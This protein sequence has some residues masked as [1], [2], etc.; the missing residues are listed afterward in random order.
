[1]NTEMEE[2][3]EI[4]RDFSILSHEIHS[5]L[6]QLE[7][8]IRRELTHAEEN[9][10]ESKTKEFNVPTLTDDESRLLFNFIT[11]KNELRDDF[12]ELI[13]EKYQSDFYKS[14]KKIQYSSEE[15]EV[16]SKTSQNL[17]RKEFT[18][19]K[20]NSRRVMNWMMEIITHNSQVI[21]KDL[22]PRNC[23]IFEEKYKRSLDEI[24]RVK[25]AWRE[26]LDRTNPTIKSP[27]EEELQAYTSEETEGEEY[28]EYS[29]HPSNAESKNFYCSSEEKLR[30]EYFSDRSR[31]ITKS[32]K[33]NNEERHEVV[34]SPP[35]QE[36]YEDE[37][38]E[39]LSNAESEDEQNLTR[40]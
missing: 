11:M 40:A 36:N 29:T 18:Y 9:P 21:A 10:S 27:A 6:K 26:S 22:D 28:E 23:Q 2:L 19:R 34:D 8:N 38:Y 30:E 24:K 4:K 3:E 1:M 7:D 17:T 12:G 13:G 16:M 15:T 33:I 39:H 35:P 14:I 32:A 37:Y 31:L 25:L 20:N 5:M